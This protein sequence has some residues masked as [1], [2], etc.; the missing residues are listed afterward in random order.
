MKLASAADGLSQ[1]VRLVPSVAKREAHMANDNVN[2]D[3]EMIVM[4]MP[5]GFGE[6]MTLIAENGGDVER[7]IIDDNGKTCAVAND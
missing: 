7:F 2:P 1:V 5:M 3:E 6:L 4:Q